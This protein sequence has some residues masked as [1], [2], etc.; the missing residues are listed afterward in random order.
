M[1]RSALTY[2]EQNWMASQ[3]RKPLYYWHREEKGS[4]AEIDYL[5]G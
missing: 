2:L 1:F 3:D 5:E 4:S